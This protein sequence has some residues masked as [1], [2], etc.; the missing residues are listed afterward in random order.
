LVIIEDIDHRAYSVGLRARQIGVGRPVRIDQTNDVVAT[1]AHI[2]A[3]G[4]RSSAVTVGKS[5]GGLVVS[6][7]NLPRYV[8]R[9][10]VRGRA[11]SERDQESSKGPH[12]C[13]TLHSIL[14]RSFSAFFDRSP[15]SRWR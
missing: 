5:L 6:P 11:Q 9:H 4:I 15:E 13:F 8:R 1:P 3:V 2:A 7:Q 12:K 14:L 10:R